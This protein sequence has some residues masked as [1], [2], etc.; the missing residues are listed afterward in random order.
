[1]RKSRID[2]LLCEAYELHQSYSPKATILQLLARAISLS[3]DT[4]LPG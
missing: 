3:N 2:L 1:M 4:L